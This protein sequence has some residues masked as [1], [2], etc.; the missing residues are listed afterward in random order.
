VFV[1]ILKEYIH[2][3]AAIVTENQNIKLLR[4]WVAKTGNIMTGRWE[5]ESN[6]EKG[7]WRDVS[8]MVATEID[9]ETDSGV[10]T[11][12]SSDNE[13]F[14]D[15]GRSRSHTP[16]PIP[17]PNQQEYT[18][19]FKTNK[20]SGHPYS[21]YELIVRLLDSGFDLS[22]AYL[23]S[24][25]TMVFR[26]IM[27]SISIKYRIQVP[28]SCT[29]TCVP[30]P[31]GTLNAGEV[32]LQLSSQLRDEKT[33]IRVGQILGDVIVTRNPCGL[34]SDVQKVKAVHCPE[35]RMYT[36]IIVF[37]VKGET[38]LASQLSGGDYDGDMVKSTLVWRLSFYTYLFL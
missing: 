13:Q 9:D 24:R 23:A 34:K 19:F 3:L 29:V 27:Q 35:L 25:V 20:Y 32:F 37:S 11:M 2:R 6:T 21:L 22:N 1:D 5:N 16:E 38:S 33:G 10:F 14:N 8:T 18:N 12:D 7:V 17:V 31:T 15:E 36:D 4:D 26:Q 30:D 28:K